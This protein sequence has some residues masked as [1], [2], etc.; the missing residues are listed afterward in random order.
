MV[1]LIGLTFIDWKS[2][3]KESN[4]LLDRSPTRNLDKNNLKAEGLENFLISL[5]EFENKDSD[6]ELRNMDHIYFIFLCCLPEKEF[7]KLLLFKDINVTTNDEIEDPRVFIMSGTLIDMLT[8]AVHKFSPKKEA[9]VFQN[10]IYEIL[11]NLGFNL[12]Y[13]KSY[14]QDGT[15]IL[16]KKG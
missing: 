5:N 10:E 2:Y 1:K 13:K 9:R 6:V 11:E 4:F 7:V 8:V 14:N 3:L 15:F 16:T 12:K